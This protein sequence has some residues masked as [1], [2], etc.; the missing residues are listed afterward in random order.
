[1]TQRLTSTSIA[2]LPRLLLSFQEQL[3]QM[4]FDPLEQTPR[5]P[6]L[7]LAA[8]VLVALL[9]LGTAGGLLAAP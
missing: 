2:G 7:R 9:A 4:R 1:M 3:L 8:A 6:L 5:L